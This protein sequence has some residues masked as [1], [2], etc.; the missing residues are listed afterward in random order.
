MYDDDP[1]ERYG[2]K[3]GPYPECV[4]PTDKIEA[5]LREYPPGSTQ[6]KVVLLGTGSYSPVHRMHVA[7]FH[8]VRAYL[9]GQG[10]FVA[11]GLMSPGHDIHVVLKLA[12][13]AIPVADRVAMCRMACQGESWLGVSTWEC[14]QQGFVDFP[15]VTRNH[16]KFFDEKFPEHHIRVIYICGA[17]LAIRCGLERGLNDLRVAAVCRP[18]YSMGNMLEVAR[19]HEPGDSLAYFYVIETDQIEDVSSTEIRRR[20][21]SPD[22]RHT[23][24]ELMLPETADYFVKHMETRTRQ[25]QQQQNAR[26]C[27]IS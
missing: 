24:E 2:L 9:E 17:D 16:R 26:S 23:L 13:K 3:L 15:S 6:P 4:I 11:G 19:P 5:R 20:A 25:Q 7:K 1:I 10:V 8:L 21:A 18:G 12:E 22:G 27:I 14:H